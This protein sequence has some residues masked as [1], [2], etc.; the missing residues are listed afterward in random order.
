MSETVAAILTQ[1]K[2]GASVR[3]SDRGFTIGSY[4]VPTDVP[5][6]CAAASQA[7]AEHGWTVIEPWDRPVAADQWITFAEWA[8][9][10]AMKES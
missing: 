1:H 7:L 3:L 5:D 8:D 9:L 10:A 2:A 6:L 4:T